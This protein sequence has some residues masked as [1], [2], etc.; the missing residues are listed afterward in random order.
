MASES[1]LPSDSSISSSSELGLYTIVR[2]FEHI[3]LKKTFEHIDL[4]KTFEYK[5]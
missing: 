5:L 2:I 3:D 1:S 4:K